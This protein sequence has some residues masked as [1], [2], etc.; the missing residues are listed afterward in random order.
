MKLLNSL[1]ATVVTHFTKVGS[2]ISVKA[3][4]SL[5]F[6]HSPNWINNLKT[7]C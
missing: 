3:L 1:G 6:F 2:G 5:L 7:T 4:M